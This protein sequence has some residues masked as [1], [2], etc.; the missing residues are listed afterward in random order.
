[1]VPFKGASS[2]K[3]YIPKKP[4]KWGYKLFI[5]ADNEGLVYDFFLTV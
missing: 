1:M 2:L 5:W 3:Q 4:H